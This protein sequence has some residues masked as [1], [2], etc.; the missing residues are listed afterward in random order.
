MDRLSV[1]QD[2]AGAGRD[3]P[4][5]AA[6]KGGL[7]A[8]I[9]ADDDGYLATRND[10]IQPFDDEAITVSGRKTVHGKGV[11]GHNEPPLRFTRTIR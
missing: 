10:K 3:K 8:G 5:H 6:K 4:R 2:L 9:G 11:A 7:A 1:E